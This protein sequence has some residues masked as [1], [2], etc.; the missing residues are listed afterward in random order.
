MKEKTKIAIA[1]IIALSLI[2]TSAFAIKT[3]LI[4]RAES[5]AKTINTE[6]AKILKETAKTRDNIAKKEIKKAKKEL[7][8]NTGLKIS[9]KFTAE[10]LG[11]YGNK[12]KKAAEDKI[13]KLI[14]KKNEKSETES[15]ITSDN[16]DYENNDNNNQGATNK[17]TI[18]N[19]DP[20][21]T[22]GNGIKKRKKYVNQDTG[23][24]S[25]ENTYLILK[26]KPTVDNLNPINPENVNYILSN[27]GYFN[28]KNELNMQVVKDGK[29]YVKKY[30]FDYINRRMIPTDKR[31]MI[32]SLIMWNVDENYL[33]TEH[34][35][36]T[37]YNGI[38]INFSDYEEFEIAGKLK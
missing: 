9:N 33:Y 7:E 29:K 30:T 32:D 1:S 12:K 37:V 14:E 34:D 16:T 17:P 8:E 23:K 4:K 5:Y 19:T 28:Q 20:E 6:I 24:I 38:N 13:K 18:P 2:V 22:N 36:K 27:I 10:Y 3:N 21:E 25:K 31:E 26:K 11:Y 15:N 35:K